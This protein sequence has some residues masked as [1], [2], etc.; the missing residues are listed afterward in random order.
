MVSVIIRN[1]NEEEFIGFALQSVCDFL[2]KAEVIIVDNNSTDDSMEVVKLFNTRLNIRTYNIEDY[3]P[4][5]A[6]NFAAERASNETLL[7]LS[8]HA[9]ITKLDMK[10][11]QLKLKEN[12][13]VFGN[14]IPIF[15]GKKITK[16]YI[17]SHFKKGTAAGFNTS[18]RG[19]HQ[20]YA[21][22]VA[23]GLA[24]SNWVSTPTFTY[25]ASNDA[26][27]QDPLDGTL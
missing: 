20:L 3:T 16:R 11:V 27:D 7:I 15:R 22:G 12:V 6:L 10:Y 4:G 21:N 5:K 18:V 9:Q 13:A 26:P 14:Q 19:V 8:A 17:W 1:R 23:A 2:P 25:T 24:L